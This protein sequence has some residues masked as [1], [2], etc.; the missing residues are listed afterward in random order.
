MLTIRF[1]SYC[2]LS[3]QNQTAPKRK[4]QNTAVPQFSASSRRP[5]WPPVSEQHSVNTTRPVGSVTNDWHFPY[6][7]LIRITRFLPLDAKN[8]KVNKRSLPA[9]ESG[10]RA[11]RRATACRGRASW[12]SRR[13]ENRPAPSRRTSCRVPATV[14]C[15]TLRQLAASRKRTTTMV[16][17]HYSNATARTE[18]QRGINITK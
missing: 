5:R 12:P 18:G 4:Q 13:V 9:T 15:T 14:G 11:V 10:S 17:A 3:F 8:E 7:Q 2:R 6:R 1:N 16:K